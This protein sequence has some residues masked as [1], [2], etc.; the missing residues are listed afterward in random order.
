MVA[1]M[2]LCNGLVDTTTLSEYQDAAR[3][4][5]LN[6][7]RVTNTAV[8]TL[9]EV[10]LS[11]EER[12]VLSRGLRFV[13]TPS[14]SN[15]TA[16]SVLSA[17][18]GFKRGCL[19]ADYFSIFQP[20]P[21]D[22]SSTPTTLHVRSPRTWAPRSSSKTWMPP[23]NTLAV[24]TALST[25]ENL[26]PG[27]CTAP[28][29]RT[30]RGA[31]LTANEYAII[32]QLSA[33]SGLVLRNA[34]KGMGLC[35]IGSEFYKRTLDLHL[36]DNSTYKLV[37]DDATVVLKDWSLRVSQVLS[38]VLGLSSTAIDTALSGCAVPKFYTMVKLHKITP[39][40]PFAS[41]P[42]TSACAAPTRFISD[43]LVSLLGP[44]TKDDGWTLSSSLQFVR[45]L[46]HNTVVIPSSA[47]M[48]SFDVEQLYPSM[49][50][51]LCIKYT[52]RRFCE[53]YKVRQSEQCVS[54][55]RSLLHLLL[56]DNFFVAPG[57]SHR[58]AVFS[59][60]SGIPMGISVAVILANIYVRY[61]LAPVFARFAKRKQCVVF[62]RHGYVDDVNSCVDASAQDVD[63]LVSWLNGACPG[64]RITCARS[65]QE[66]QFLDMVISKG[67][68]WRKSGGLYLDMRVFVKPNNLHLYIPWSSCHPRAA[69][70][71]Y[72]AGE[73]RRYVCLS[74]CEAA[75]LE[76]S[77]ALVVA[78]RARGYPLG[79]IVRQLSSI[80][81]GERRRYLGLDAHTPTCGCS[82]DTLVSTHTC[83]DSND[84]HTTRT[85]STSNDT[86][87][88]RVL[89]TRTV[90]LVLP[91][92]PTLHSLRVAD[93]LRNSFVSVPHI[94]PVI[95]WSNNDNLQR[96]L[97]LQWPKEQSSMDQRL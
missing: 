63:L 43:V 54:A 67:D 9:G 32:K 74:T 1:D 70:S 26:L 90:A 86:K 13:P 51:D 49:R 64:L 23:K 81:Y 35:V 83:G 24:T 22:S 45:I 76:Q 85:S 96:K 84:T 92:S 42:I 16:T 79:V 73:A 21:I 29:Q 52:A 89:S 91:Y 75:A 3:R 19:L 37:G 44:L 5:M 39:S 46:E 10:S 20:N 11:N 61:A 15:N 57:S 47:T 69:L 80:K 88:T 87:Q 41:R 82:N 40:T 2:D 14:P 56:T 60:I 17:F 62:W 4:R 71:G 12:D 72:I 48:L 78:L 30:A 95:A 58:G 31:N 55:L 65:Q 94:R 36:A 25:F 68:R 59:Q 34:D 33:R 97:R 66:V 50:V 93:A 6:Y 53:Y 27:L 28:S 7:G 8:H 38:S 77:R 18:P